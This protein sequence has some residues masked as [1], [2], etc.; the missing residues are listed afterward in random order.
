MNRDAQ[1]GADRKL[2]VLSEH[3]SEVLNDPKSRF[4]AIKI[5]ILIFKLTHSL[6]SLTGSFYFTQ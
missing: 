1:G 3:L 2:E 5:Y 4:A 6:I